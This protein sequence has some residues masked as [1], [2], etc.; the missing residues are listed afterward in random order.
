MSIKLDPREVLYYLND[1]GYRNIT[2]QQ[3]KEFMKGK[4]FFDGINLKFH[5]CFVILCSG[6]EV[7]KFLKFFF[8]Y[9]F[10]K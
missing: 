6:V 3:L 4:Y 5:S 1:L 7:I 9:W 2:A 10:N 8:I